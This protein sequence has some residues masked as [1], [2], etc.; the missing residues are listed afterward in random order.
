MGSAVKYAKY[1]RYFE[2]L[3]P[4]L[5]VP[6]AVIAGALSAY[7]VAFGSLTWNSER[8]GGEGS[9]ARV[10]DRRG[11]RRSSTPRRPGVVK[12][13]TLHHNVLAG[14]ISRRMGL[15]SWRSAHRRLLATGAD[16][17]LCGHDHQEGAGQVKG[18]LAVS[19]AGTHS[20]RTRRGPP[21]GVQP[22]HDRRQAVHVQH[23]RWESS[24]R[25]F[26]KSDTSFVRPAGPRAGRG[27]GGRRRGAG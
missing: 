21:V 3:T 16:V 25:R 8:P 5:E 9:P 6:G 4:V 7:G 23:Y 20:F 14:G 26:L 11:S 17:I 10:R 24:A 2:P 27:L 19:T 18:A 13:L 12:I 1:S 15:A 22:G